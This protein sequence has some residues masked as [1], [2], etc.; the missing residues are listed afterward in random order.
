MTQ[1]VGSSN[2]RRRVPSSSKAKNYTILRDSDTSVYMRC[3]FNRAKPWCLV[4]VPD[5][6][7]D[8]RAFASLNMLQVFRFLL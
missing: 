2:N 3:L 5:Y 1:I 6:I 8:P 7:F 4:S